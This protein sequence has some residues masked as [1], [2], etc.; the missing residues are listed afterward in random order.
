MAALLGAV[1]LAVLAERPTPLSWAGLAV[2][3][4]A[5]AALSPRDR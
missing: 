3:L 2:L 4:L 1:V 5:L